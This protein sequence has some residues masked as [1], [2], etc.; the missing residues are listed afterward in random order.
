MFSLFILWLYNQTLHNLISENI[1]STGVLN[2]V[3]TGPIVYATL[4]WRGDWS[5]SPFVLINFHFLKE[6]ASWG[7]M[8]WWIP[9]VHYFYT[10]GQYNSLFVSFLLLFIFLRKTLFEGIHCVDSTESTTSSQQAN[11]L[12]RVRRI[13]ILIHYCS[14]F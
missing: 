10:T 1:K 11:T 7:N 14:T 12:A 6:N 4:V 9:R 5:E 2:I 3:S 8:L 13:L